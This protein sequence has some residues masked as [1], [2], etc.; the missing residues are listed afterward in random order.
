VFAQLSADSR[1]D[2]VPLAIFD[3][4]SVRDGDISVRFKP[5]SGHEEQ[6]GGLVFRYRDER[7]YYLVRANARE[8]DVMVWKV[9]NGRSSPLT[10]RG[11]IKA[12]QYAVKRD[13]QPDA[14]HILKVSFRGNRF[15]VYVNHRRVLQ[16]ED[17]T[18]VGPGKVGLSTAGDSIT[19]FDD[20]R[21]YPK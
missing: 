16:T 12:T 11:G 5:L 15:Q 2:R 8:D 21:V 17:S 18:F 19:Y 10:P 6:S 4:A 9:E 1:Q 20:F 7:N 14:W 3:G 13:I